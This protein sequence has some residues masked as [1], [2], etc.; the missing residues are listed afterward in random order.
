MHLALKCQVKKNKTE[1]LD[2]KCKVSVINYLLNTIFCQVDVF[3]GGKKITPSI[4]THAW[5]A[6]FE[7]LLNYG[8]DAKSTHLETAGYKKDTA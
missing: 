3:L 1:D 5:R 6:I 4:A 8:K 7:V 2:E